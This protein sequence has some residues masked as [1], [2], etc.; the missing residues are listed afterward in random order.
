[1]KRNGRKAALLSF[2]ILLP[3]LFPAHAFDETL[4]KDVE[5]LRNS[6]SLKEPQRRTLGLRLAD[7]FFE[8]STALGR[9]LTPTES[10]VA[11]LQKYRRRAVSL[12]EEALNGTDGFALPAG[13]LKLNI[14]FQLAR[15]YSDL[16]QDAKSTPLWLV[17]IEQ[18]ESRQLKREAALRLA[19][20]AEK[21]KAKT[22][23]AEAHRYYSEAI[24]LCEGGDLCSYVHY[25]R[26]WLLKN[27][28][29]LSE[30]IQEMQSAL[31]DSKNQVREEAVRDYVT[32]LGAE[33][34]DGKAALMLIEELAGKLSRPQLFQDLSNAFFSAG[35][36]VAGTSV[37]EYINQ[38]TP[39][40]KF[41]VR[42]MEELY[43]LRQWDKFR[44]IRGQ[45]LTS[46]PNGSDKN[47]SVEIE[48]ILRRLTVQ[49]DGERI[50]QPQLAADFRATVDLYLQLFPTGPE[51]FKMMEGWLASETDAVKKSDQLKYWLTTPALVLNKEEEIK[52]RE[53]RISQGRQ[54]KN[55]AVI[56]EEL[57]LLIPLA[58]D[59]KTAREYRFNQA[60][61]YFEAKRY[62]E[63][64]PLL[65]SLAAQRA[66]EKP[67]TFSLKSRL[68]LL[69]ILGQQKKY[70]ELMTAAEVWIESG[71]EIRNPDEEFK[72]GL[73]EWKNTREAAEF[74]FA[75][76]QGR[77]ETALA[78]FKRYCLEK[79]YFPKSCEN[80]KVLAIQLKDQE[81]LLASLNAMGLSD[82]LADE[83]EAAGFFLQA[84]ALLE[85][86]L[87][88]KITEI[89]P[90]LKVALLY[91]LAGRNDLRDQR[92]RS[93]TPY[94]VAKKELGKDEGLLYQTYQ[95][96]SLLDAS[97]LRLPWSHETKLQIAENL[98]ERGQGNPQTKKMLMDS[99]VSVGPQWAKLVLEKLEKLDQS[100]RQQKFY[101]AKSQRRFETRLAKLKTFIHESET[102]YKGADTKTRVDIARI[103]EK[104]QADL[105]HEI[106][107]TPL[108]EGLD[109]QATAEIKGALRKMAE[110]FEARAKEYAA[111]YSEPAQVASPIVASADGLRPGAVLSEGQPVKP[112]ATKEVFESA[113]KTLHRDPTAIHALSEIQRFY[114]EKGQLRLA[115]YFQGRIRNLE[116]TKETP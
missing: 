89:I 85:K 10:D 60:V 93:L 63:A 53:F 113:L 82:Q 36:R 71:A 59:E 92:I 34:S 91:E 90:S 61:A 7:L 70:Q 18:N 110:P 23:V 112:P 62:T 5:T 48:K 106:L 1:M 14:Q 99:K 2:L 66:D 33:N 95:E 16:E 65:V 37:L 116:K 77:T 52:L 103:M 29:R 86:K 57:A 54:T 101:G 4:L 56:L 115:S 30:A 38:R 94:L 31:F 109:E 75:V 15:L 81:A 35:N 6:L 45:A 11:N 43:G 102:Y 104:A 44:E 84:A 28:G 105:A 47:E 69:D 8:G 55:P 39:H 100:Q 40:L 98:E 87:P 88:P 78:T 111:L 26:A 46:V 58:R 3:A 24:S 27:D 13:M 50:S 17:L 20:R 74:E 79:K 107:S 64:Q 67:D 97:S 12:Y 83:Y 19:E 49:L 73:I 76:S 96:A 9:N 72:K 32:F 42:L 68:I 41:Q 21:S 51:R 25:R 114:E 22:A 80:A 108:P